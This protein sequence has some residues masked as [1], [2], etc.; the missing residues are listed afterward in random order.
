MSELPPRHAAQSGA[1]TG[2]WPTLSVIGSAGQISPEAYAITEALGRAAVDAGFRIACGGRDGVMEAACRG[3]HQ[4]D[5]YL[6]G[7][8]IG[9][10]PGYGHDGANPWVDITIPTG[11]A[12]ARN[13]MVVSAGDVVV[14]VSG[15]SGTLS[16]IAL[17]WQI[18]RP[19][20]ALVGSGGWTD[21]LAGRGL[22]TRRT[23]V[24]EPFEDPRLLVARARVLAAEARLRPVVEF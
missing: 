13:M 7:A 2:R 6:P 15:G 9:V 22:D 24:I 16:E 23:D 20:L 3:A 5:A 11:L 8:T 1:R 21:E 17:A 14:A 4:S 12:F 18:G 10:L 19:V